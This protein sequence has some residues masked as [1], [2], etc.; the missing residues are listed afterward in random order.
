[1]SDEAALLAAIRANPEEDT[2]RLMYA[3]W[4]EEQGGASNTDRAEYI[5][6]EIDIARAESSDPGADLA[7]ERKRARQLCARHDWFPEF[8]GRKNLL[9]RTGTYVERSRG[10]PDHLDARNPGPFLDVAEEV[11]ALAPITRVSLAY[12]EEYILGR[13]ATAAWLE[14]LRRLTLSGYD[15]TGTDWGLLADCPHL[16][17]LREL[18]LGRGSLD[19]DGAARFAAKNPCPRLRKF[20]LSASLDDSAVRRLFAGRAFHG[21]EELKFIDPGFG[22]KG[23]QAVASADS[24]AKLKSFAPPGYPI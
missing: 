10:F 7:A 6:L 2:P 20:S 8:I 13:L 11:I 21:L 24:L 5:R 9:R 19:S 23:L 3:D 16:Q 22:A 18:H 1:M 12:V 4:L 17:N 14:R 15:G